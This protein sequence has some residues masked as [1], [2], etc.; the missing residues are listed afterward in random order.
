MHRDRKPFY[1]T[2]IFWQLIVIIVAVAVIVL[3]VIACLH[4]F[5]QWKQNAEKGTAITSA[6]TETE[7]PT[8]PP[9]PANPYSTMDFYYE[10]GYMTC[11]A[12]DSSLGI[13][14]SY[15]QGDIDWEQVKNAGIEFVMI[16]AGYRGSIEGKLDTDSY[17]R[18]N[19][20]GAKAA[21]LKVGAYIF[22]QAVNPEEAVEEADYLMDLV[23]DWEVDMPLV[24]DWEIVD[25][26]SRN[27]GLDSDTLTESALAFCRRVEEKGYDAMV[28]F[29]K[30]H[31]T[32]Y[33][34]L[35]QLVDYGFWLAMYDPY[36]DYPYR[37]DL[38]QY[39][40]EGTVPGI[41]GKVDIN[42]QLHYD[43]K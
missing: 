41:E 19:Y 23:K 13:D 11:G 3:G 25:M 32:G 33:L 40:D 14:V 10:N 17:A 18:K 27:A 22:S 9:P 42:L 6:P 35:S 1:K 30:N 8:L 2:Q 39:T 26:E 4:Y 38:W 7:E 15:W 21:G 12:G 31:S 43:Q 29:N 16:R 34:D 37:V 5:P 20:E 28:Y 36:M 24:F